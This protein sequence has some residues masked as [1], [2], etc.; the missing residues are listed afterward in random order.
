MRTLLL[1]LISL[2]STLATGQ[3]LSI[4]SPQQPSEVI[5]TAT[6][7][8]PQDNELVKAAQHDPW[9][10]P[11]IIII[12]WGDDISPKAPK[13]HSAKPYDLKSTT[14]SATHTYKAE[15]D[16]TIT[17]LV[18]D[19]KNRNIIQESLPIKVNKLVE[20]R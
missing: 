17:I 14:Q 18:N 7:T 4:S 15:G 1:L 16:Y 10:Q 3:N 20:A 9:M 11:A 2:I 8:L 19:R 12:F 6:Y 13:S 5:V